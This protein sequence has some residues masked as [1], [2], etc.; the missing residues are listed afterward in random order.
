MA[1]R[2]KKDTRTRRAVH[3]YSRDAN[4]LAVVGWYEQ[5]SIKESFDGTVEDPA[6]TSRLL[7][8]NSGAWVEERDYNRG[9][10]GPV[11]YRASR[12]DAALWLI[13]HGYDQ[14]ADDRF[15]GEVEAT[16]L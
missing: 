10:R 3:S 5:A 14:I 16:R 6:Y 8:L 12:R 1:G 2:T 13:K 4:R 7:E 15:P 11:A 9:G